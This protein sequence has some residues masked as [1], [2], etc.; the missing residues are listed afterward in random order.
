MYVSCVEI[1][2]LGKCDGDGRL[3]GNLVRESHELLLLCLK[4]VQKVAHI[5]FCQKYPGVIL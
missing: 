4:C 1:T 5:W 2:H 3:H